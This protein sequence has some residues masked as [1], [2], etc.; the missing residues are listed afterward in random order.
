MAKISLVDKNAIQ[1]I[2]LIINKINTL[3]ETLDNL[4]SKDVKFSINETE[5][6]KIVNELTVK[7]S[8]DLEIDK[9]AL[10]KI[11]KQIKDSLTGVIVD[12]SGTKSPEFKEETLEETKTNLNSYIVAIK[13]DILNEIKKLETL[14]K[15]TTKETSKIFNNSN[16]I[17]T[18]KKKS[19]QLTSKELREKNFS[20]FLRN[21][22]KEKYANSFEDNRLAFNSDKLYMQLQQAIMKRQLA[23][24]KTQLSSS[25]ID[26]RQNNLQSNQFNSELNTSKKNAQKN[27]EEVVK[28]VED[29]AKKIA[30]KIITETKKISK[31]TEKTSGES[32]NK[33]ESTSKKRYSGKYDYYTSFEQ[34]DIEAFLKSFRDGDVEKLSEAIS[35]LENKYGRSGIKDITSIGKG[36]A[37]NDA[38][39]GKEA[40]ELKNLISAEAT[41]R[42]SLRAQDNIF[43]ILQ[44]INSPMGLARM[45]SNSFTDFLTKSAE[46]KQIQNTNVYKK[47]AETNNLDPKDKTTYEKFTKD[48]KSYAIS[49]KSVLGDSEAMSEISKA[50]TIGSAISIAVS[51]L[52][53]LG[54]AAV[55]FGKNAVASYENIQSLQTRMAVIYGSQTEAT[56]SFNEIEQYA[57]KSPFGIEMMTQQAILLKQSGVAGKD[58]MNT[59]QR[60][61]DVASGNAEKMRSVSET[62]ARIMSSTTVTARDMRQL[63][64]AGIP[65]YSALANSLRKN[66][67][68]VYNYDLN[69]SANISNA[70]IRSMLQTGKITSEDFV[71]MIKELTNKG[72]TFYGATDRGAQTILAR[73]QNLSDMKQMAL[74]AIGENITQWGNTK[75]NNSWYNTLL[76]IREGVWETVENTAKEKKGKKDK[77]IQQ[78]ASLQAALYQRKADNATSEEER[79]F[80]LNKKNEY[81]NIAMNKYMLN[82]SSL[83]DKYDE[84]SKELEKP[85]LGQ[86]QQQQ[87]SESFN[88]YLTSSL[89]SAGNPLG[90][91]G[92][93]LIYL[94]ETEEERTNFATQKERNET[95]A[96]LRKLIPAKALTLFEKSLSRGAESV[97]EF[98]NSINGSQTRMLKAKSNYDSSSYGSYK[99]TLQQR[100]QD[101]QLRARL[102]GYTGYFSNGK[103]NNRAL[104]YNAGFLTR[105]N[106]LKDAAA[107]AEQLP[108]NFSELFE[109]VGTNANL[110]TNALSNWQKYTDN[111][112]TFAQ[113]FENMP[114]EFKQKSGLGNSLRI[115]L[116]KISESANGN[117][118]QE[119]YQS[120]TVARMEFEK[121]LTDSIARLSNKQNKTEEDKKLLANLE[122]TKIVFDATGSNI[123]YDISNK[124]MLNK[125]TSPLLIQSILGN[126]AGVDSAI[127]KKLSEDNKLSNN[128]I[129][130][131]F[132]NPMMNKNAFGSLTTSLLNAGMSLKQISQSLKIDTDANNRIKKDINNKLIDDNKLTAYDWTTS[133]NGLE[134]FAE[135][136]TLEQRQAVVSN[137]EAQLNQLTDI[138]AKG[139]TTTE[140]LEDIVDPASEL[141]AALSFATQ[142]LKDGSIEFKDTLLETVDNMSNELREKILNLKL[143]NIIKSSLEKV[144]LDTLSTVT[145]TS[146]LTNGSSY[147][148]NSQQVLIKNSDVIST[149]TNSLLEEARKESFNGITKRVFSNQGALQV[150]DFLDNIYLLS[151]KTKNDLLSITKDGGEVDYKPEYYIDPLKVDEVLRNLDEKAKNGE[152]NLEQEKIWNETLSL[153][154]LTNDAMSKYINSLEALDEATK[155]LE[156]TQESINNQSKLN[157]I[158]QNSLGFKNYGQQEN[159]GS[160]Q[161]LTGRKNRT[162][163]NS[164]AEKEYLS[165]LGYAE[166]TKLDDVYKSISDNY[167]NFLYNTSIQKLK[168]QVN[169]NVKF[170]SN[171]HSER[172]ESYLTTVKER[173]K[174][175]EDLNNISKEFDVAT[176]DWL[177]KGEQN[178]ALRVK[179]NESLNDNTQL[180]IIDKQLNESEIDYKNANDYL[181][182]LFSQKKEKER[183]LSEIQ[184]KEN[185]LKKVSDENIFTNQISEELTWNTQ[186]ENVSDELNNYISNN[187]QLLG[188]VGQY[189]SNGG[190]AYLLK[191]TS[192]ENGKDSIEYK[193]LEK[194]LSNITSNGEFNGDLLGVTNILSQLDDMSLTDKLSEGLSKSVVMTNELAKSFEQLGVTIRDTFDNAL[195]NTYLSGMKNLGT[196]QYKLSTNAMTQEEATKQITK[197][198]AGQAS[199]LLETL[200]TQMATTGL[201]IA[202]AAALSHNWGGV[203]AGLL[204]AAAG[205]IGNF[206]SGILSGYAGDNDKDDDKLERIEA[207]K[208]NLAD[209][210]EQ[211]RNDAEY[212]ETTLRNKSALSFNERVS[213]TKVN[214]MI[215]TPQGN[216]STSPQDYLIATKNPYSLTGNTPNIS[217]SIVN[218][219]EPVKIESTQQTNS[220]NGID[221]RV[222]INSVVRKSM[223]DGD[224]DDTFKS[225]SLRQQG[226]IVSA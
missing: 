144:N 211:A 167:K 34:S 94:R 174:I 85:L 158:M 171:V 33:S 70:S 84:L 37:Y 17:P 73:K 80:Y 5:L 165:V 56:S 99:L 135:Q 54:Q 64:N 38:T 28:T 146:L 195:L 32:K 41:M 154:L 137:Y 206:A 122:N 164:K 29:M 21:S 71:N 67:A 114:E 74:A 123:E 86:Q 93:G 9:N 15:S 194:S 129:F 217:F 157:D 183:E 43:S 23:Q 218:N 175:E 202:G 53:K 189:L 182:A 190:G 88:K 97:N 226:N 58:L 62:Y 20:D 90:M 196:I 148:N 119:T 166:D 1:S 27:I 224:Y 19:R 134:R 124:D 180:E 78:S 111:I 48:K 143:D 161:N 140:G 16:N 184:K 102:N 188:N 79:E 159:E 193:S 205:G 199:A 76:D 10:D 49:L 82:V 105:A 108:I 185:S 128:K 222:V 139:I 150:K 8:L 98:A 50:S 121:H 155:K 212:Y 52:V 25:L 131:Q 210:I 65:A 57:K 4:S 177:S 126:A 116:K 51:G 39:Y 61:G 87:I 91:L 138:I 46:T 163:F 36:L 187:S 221:L 92:P 149:L 201:Q 160:L 104:K 12:T 14:K 18:S 109:M 142:N 107:S 110:K 103:I 89:L 151:G 168:E 120:A 169:K 118:T 136:G 147:F 75:G 191:E 192:K 203:A 24:Q 209:L 77:E 72:G 176:K 2:D 219:G 127:I 26:Q 208:N 44:G 181:T 133:L 81:A 63:A 162:A 42:G 117:L 13:K 215:L 96:Q 6:K 220:N 186:R 198:L 113:N 153:M 125:R 101:A 213:A 170:Q 31:E 11:K 83:S 35:N 214:D 22:Y 152:L 60:I 3:N 145:K 178:N 197:D 100:E 66:G 207:L 40:R 106:L 225:I 223:N 69:R 68:S 179:Y 45:V 115:F 130:K 200:S 204:L 30:T 172:K 132:V 156:K 216:F 59:M 7:K 55:D 173:Q 47:W 95:L 141:G 112:T